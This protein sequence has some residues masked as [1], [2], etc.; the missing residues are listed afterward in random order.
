MTV[1]HSHNYTAYWESST[2]EIFPLSQTL[3]VRKICNSSH[4]TQVFLATLLSLSERT[5]KLTDL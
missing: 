3:F 4:F 5:Q 2:E 1:P